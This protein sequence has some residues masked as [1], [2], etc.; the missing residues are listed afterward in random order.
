MALLRQLAREKQSAV[1]VRPSSERRVLQDTVPLRSAS[2]IPSIAR[3][4]AA[5]F[6][7]GAT[8]FGGPAMIAYMRTMAVEQRQWL[9]ENTFRDG[10]V[11]C[12]TIPGATAMQM[13]AY[14][15]LRVQGVTGAAASFVGFGLPAFLLMVVLSALYIRT[16]TVP[17]VVALTGVAQGQPVP[18]VPSGWT[19]TF[20]TQRWPR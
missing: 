1:E 16:Q 3:L 19:F 18:K 20:P 7:L 2:R 5:F 13:S 10:V 11:L 12:Q 4:F 17:T 15:G 14:I 6:R 8:A 9:E